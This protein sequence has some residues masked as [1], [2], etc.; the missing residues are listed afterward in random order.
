MA[1][2]SQELLLDYGTVCILNRFQVTYQ[3]SRLIPLMSNMLTFGEK[4]GSKFVF[5]NLYHVMVE[6]KGTLI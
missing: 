4:K 2:S 1:G 5:E 3:I 6:A